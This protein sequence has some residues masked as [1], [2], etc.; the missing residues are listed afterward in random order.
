MRLLNKSDNR[1]LIIQDNHGLSIL[2]SLERRD[3]EKFVKSDVISQALSTK[4]DH[5]TTDDPLAALAYCLNE[6]GKVDIPFISNALGQIP[7]S[8]IMQLGDHIYLN[9]EKNEWETADQ[10]LSGNVVSKLEAALIKTEDQKEPDEQLQRSLEA[11]KKSA[12]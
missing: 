9:P 2:A 12:A 1:K 10:Y 5:F 7:A 4:N 6:Q 3:G 11:I 8:V